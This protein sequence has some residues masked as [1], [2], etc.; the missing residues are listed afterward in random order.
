MNK[1]SIL[2]KVSIKFPVNKLYYMGMHPTGKDA[3]E[4]LFS[5]SSYLFQ[6][7]NSR[8]ATR[9]EHITDIA[10]DYIIEHLN[11]E[12]SLIMLADKV[13]LNPSYFS[14]LFKTKTGMNVSEFIKNERIKKAKSL[15]QDKKYRINEIAKMIG[16]NNAAYFTKFFKAQMG[17]SPQEYRDNVL[18]Q[19]KLI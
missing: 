2:E 1:T 14:V 10:R 5:V 16:Y 18:M 6:I 7:Q 4:Y 9:S 3:S 19:H 17:I 11:E 13:Y 12:L 8:K 15:L